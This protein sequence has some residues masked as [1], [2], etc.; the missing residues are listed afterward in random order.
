MPRKA[1]ANRLYTGRLQ[2]TAIWCTVYCAK[3]QYTILM[4]IESYKMI[5]FLLFHSFD[6]MSFQEEFNVKMREIIESKKGT[7]VLFSEERY[8]GL[9]TRME[10]IV[11]DGCNNSSDRYYFSIFELHAVGE[12]RKLVK[13]KTGQ[14]VAHPAKVFEILHNTHQSLGHCGRDIMLKKLAKYVNINRELVMTYLNLCENCRLKQNKAKKGLVVQPIISKEFN[15]RCQVDLIDMQTSPDGEFKYI[16]NYQDHHTKFVDLRPLKS[17]RATEV[18]NHLVDIF[19]DKGPP[20][21]LQS[22]NGRE[23]CN[24]VSKY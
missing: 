11:K 6:K 20:H 17:K 12:E 16:M 24:S 18:A 23:F 14:E 2:S 15:H 4:V 9:L 7:S 13:S 5:C 22:D 1:F 3:R 19:C 10:K 8:A 21:I